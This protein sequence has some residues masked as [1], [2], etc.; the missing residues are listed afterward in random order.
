MKNKFGGA[1][2]SAQPVPSAD[3]G[4]G[5]KDWDD[6]YVMMKLTMLTLVVYLV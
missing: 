2:L 1:C 4:K 3:S 5:I 6:I